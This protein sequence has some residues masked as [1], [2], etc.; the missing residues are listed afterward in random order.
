[1]K[2]ILYR[3]QT[4]C[5]ILALFLTGSIFS[6]GGQE[7]DTLKSSSD[8]L[9]NI[10]YGQQKTEAIG[11]AISTIGAEVLEKNSVT[12][13]GNALFGRL[14]G[15][16]VNQNGGE[17]GN[18]YPS[19]SIRANSSYAGGNNP[20]IIIDGFQRGIDLLVVDEIESISVLKDAAATAMYGI[21][22][23]NGVILITTKRGYA[24]KEKIDVSLKYGMQE[25]TRLPNFINSYDYAMLFNEARVNDGLQPLYSD[26]DLQKYKDGS[27]PYLHPDV[28]WF[29][30]I[31]RKSSPVAEA[32]ISFR[33]GNSVVRHFVLVDYMVNQGLLTNTD[34]NDRFSTESSFKRLNFRSNID[35]NVTKRLF[36]SLLINGS[37]QDYNSPATAVSTI[38]NNIYTYAPN[39][40]PVLNPDGTFGGNSAYQGNMLGQVTSSGYS[41]KNDRNFQSSFRIEHDLD[42]IAEGLK[43]G[44]VIGFDNWF[45]VTETY[46]KQ[47]PVFQL[48]A[49]TTSA[50]TYSKFGQV[51]SLSRAV[52]HTHNI[53]TNFEA[54][55][56]YTKKYGLSEVTAKLLYHQDSYII[57][58]TIGN[59]TPYLLNGMSG[60]VSY[61]YNDRYFA[62]L[63]AGYNGTER[64]PKNNQFGFFPAA[65]ISWVLSEE[66]FMKSKTWINYLKARASYG[67]VGND[68]IGAGGDRYLYISYYTNTGSYP[69]GDSNAALTTTQESN[70]PNYNITWEKS[71]KTDLGIDG[72]FF[73]CLDVSLGYFHE[74]R[75][76]IV[77]TRTNELPSIL[78]ITAGYVNNG[79]VTRK[80]VEGT[81][82]FTKESGDFSYS[83]GVNGIL[84]NSQI[85]ERFE[86]AYPNAY[87]YRVGHPVNQYFGLEAIGFLTQEDIS[88][89]GTPVY[90]FT[91]VK[92]GDVKYKDQDNNGL[93]DANDE[94]AIG[95]SSNPTLY[96]GFN[97][98]IKYKAIS[99]EGILQGAGGMDLWINGLSGP[100]G[101]KAQISEYV[102]KRWTPSTAATAEFP[103]LT[104]VANANN[105]R[106]STLWLQ[107]GDYLRL[108]SLELGFDV[109]GSYLTS[110]QISGIRLYIQGKNLL[111]FDDIKNLDPENFTG[112]P[113]LKSYFAGL[114]I[115]F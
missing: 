61:G 7:T 102:M 74:K 47:F 40:F 8:K 51:T 69:Y 25:P 48:T 64:F 31:L 3:I 54:Y 78:G 112:Y 53:R 67:L 34:W 114:R 36:A 16:M 96:Y 108:R 14:A 89:P 110:L 4:A 103:R 81:L 97:F 87:Q 28:N 66:G 11:G 111:T 101:N 98:G 59:N 77:D 68:D 24:G 109:P 85:E 29:D 19:L 73:N 32:G 99:L 95:R 71:F 106:A 62:E 88:N 60:R 1:M 83:L 46:S 65:A 15:L 100:M 82:Q 27:D 113:A 13:I 56:D 76:D 9:I 17:P 42:F 105:Y 37:I 30:E 26:L 41:G 79:V 86:P 43:A 38:F 33:G 21:K 49:G 39:L 104:T 20:L 93:I 6:A 57:N 45:R 91:Q 58:W 63:V 55:L 10:A 18:D 72:R 70:Y 115:Q 52:A 84:T 2:D 22:A 23:A 35:V 94:L 92:P 80:G 5:F 107:S 75:T 44:A 90:T 12:N 50:Y